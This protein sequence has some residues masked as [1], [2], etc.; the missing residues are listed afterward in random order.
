MIGLVNA[1]NQLLADINN[2]L[3]Q[4]LEESSVK[5]VANQYGILFFN[6]ADNTYALRVVELP[7]DWNL[8]IMQTLTTEEKSMIQD[9]SNGWILQEI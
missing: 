3:H 1:D 7:E 4:A 8:V 9:I 2:K 6:E 5:Y